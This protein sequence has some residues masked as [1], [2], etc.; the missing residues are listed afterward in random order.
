MRTILII[1]AVIVVVVLIIYFTRGNKSGNTT[2]NPNQT[3]PPT[4]VTHSG[5]LN[6][7]TVTYSSQNGKYYK[8]VSAG[9]AGFGGQLPPQEISKDVYDAACKGYLNPTSTSAIS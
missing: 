1:I 7:E 9:F 3:C 4:F 2:T 5:I 8:Q 6:L